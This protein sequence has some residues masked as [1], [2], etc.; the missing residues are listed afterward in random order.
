MISPAAQDPAATA[1]PVA[2][3]AAPAA[4]AA[5]EGGP[6][7]LEAESEAAVE[8]KIE[9]L[10]PT[11]YDKL[12]AEATTPFRSLRMFVYGGFATGAGVGS[13]TAI[14]QLIKSVQGF[15]SNC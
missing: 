9:G 3:P 10:S 4:A 6:A 1:V 13:F 8:P 14:P 2:A 11:M 5:A 7:A 15:V 12:R